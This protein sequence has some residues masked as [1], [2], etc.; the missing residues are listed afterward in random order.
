MSADFENQLQRQPLREIPRQW[1][2]E[3]LSAAS[4]PGPSPFVLRLSSWLWPHPR[5]WAGLAAAWVVILLLHLTAPDE[6]RLARSSYSQT[7]QSI[8]IMRQQE[9]IMAQLL[10]SMENDFSSPAL[11]A[12]PKPRGERDLKQLVG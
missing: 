7:P 6:P 3:I 10:S 9:L 11:P 8:A 4:G 1:R 12:A 2:A 5:A